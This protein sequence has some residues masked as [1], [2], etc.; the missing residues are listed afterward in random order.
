MTDKNKSDIL[1]RADTGEVRLIYEQ[2]LGRYIGFAVAPKDHPIC[3]ALAIG[4]AVLLAAD[5]LDCDLGEV[6]SQYVRDENDGSI[7]AASVYIPL[8]P[9]P[10]AGLAW[11]KSLPNG[12]R[13]QSPHGAK[14]VK[15]TDGLYNQYGTVW[16]W[17]VAGD[18]E[19]S[20][21]VHEASPETCTGWKPEND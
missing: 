10:L 11:L 19:E 4:Q 13:V 5:K 16:T 12:T 6:C 17:N 1:I 21:W 2:G 14:F 9:R 7:S 15:L 8:S 3:Q 20:C 18:T